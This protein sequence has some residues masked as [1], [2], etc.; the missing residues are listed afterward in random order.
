MPYFAPPA[1]NEI[2]ATP[3][4]SNAVGKA[5]F[6]KLWDYVTA[7]LG[8]SGNPEDA[9][10]ALKLTDSKRTRPAM[11]CTM[12]AKRKKLPKYQLKES[13]QQFQLRKGKNMK[14]FYRK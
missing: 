14:F 13:W 6:G 10:D 3:S 4:P 2:S 7:L 1:K 11:P 8:A 5:G 9:F 12:A